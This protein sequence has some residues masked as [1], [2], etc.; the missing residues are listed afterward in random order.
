M[1]NEEDRPLEDDGRE[2]HDDVYDSFASFASSSIQDRL[3]SAKLPSSGKF[4]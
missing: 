2:E 1:T 4:A 3:S